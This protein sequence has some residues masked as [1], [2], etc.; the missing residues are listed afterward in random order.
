MGADLVVHGHVAAADR[1]DV[2]VVLV[3]L[4][5]VLL[6]LFHIRAAVGADLVVSRHVA[7]AH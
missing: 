5:R 3:R 2:S 6:Y 1:A 7:A 4:G